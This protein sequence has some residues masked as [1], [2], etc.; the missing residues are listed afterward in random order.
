MGTLLGEINLGMCFK[1]VEGLAEFYV[2]N[3]INSDTTVISYFL[4]FAKL[5]FPLMCDMNEGTYNGVPLF[6]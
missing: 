5:L 6:Q 3:S 4:C 2:N 1:T